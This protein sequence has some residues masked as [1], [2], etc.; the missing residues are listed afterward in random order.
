MSPRCRVLAMLSISLGAAGGV[1]GAEEPAVPLT[2][3]DTRAQLVYTPVVPC[4]V[5]DTRAAGGNLAPG[6]PRDFRVTGVDLSSQ[7]GDVAGCNVPQGRA[8]A[9][10]VNLVSV[11]ATGAGNLRA[12]AYPR[13][14]W[15]RPAPAS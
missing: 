10:L 14:R 13:R 2:I 9:V 3:G 15:P 4:R 5:L 7:G 8:T 12:W 11:N 1:A 6:I